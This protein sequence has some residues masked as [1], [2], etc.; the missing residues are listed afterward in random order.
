MANFIPFDPKKH[1]PVDAVSLGLPGAK[2][3][4]K[5][6]EFLASEKAPDG[7]AW[8][9]PTI[10]FNEKTGEPTYFENIDTAWNKA[11]AYE[12]RTGKK[13]PRFET[14]PLA[15]AAAKGR[16]KRGGATKEELVT[17]KPRLLFRKDE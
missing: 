12:E 9:I 1:K 16:S 8:N 13:F 6:T 15:V 7:G 17:G 2:P 3:G 5:A 11:K 14:L 4:Q 10:W